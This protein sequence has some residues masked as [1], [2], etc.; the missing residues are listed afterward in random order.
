M[1]QFADVLAETGLK[2]EDIVGYLLTAANLLP[3]SSLFACV[4]L[5]L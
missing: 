5:V 1:E 4:C 3:F 2:I